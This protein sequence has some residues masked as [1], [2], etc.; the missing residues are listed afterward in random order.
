MSRN[1][2][3]RSSL[4]AH[5]FPSFYACYLLKSIQTPQSRATYIGSTPNPPRRIRQHNGEITQ[6]AW[7]TKNKRPWVMQMIVHGFPSKLAAL[8]FEWAWQHPHISRHLRDDTGK[9]IFMDSR[10]SKYLKMNI[11][12]VRRMISNHPYNTWPL[13]VKLFTEEAVKCWREVV[14]DAG[15][16]PLPPGFTSTIE[17]EGVDGNSGNPGSGRLGPI[18]VNDEAFT[19]AYLAKTTALLATSRPLEC[20]ICREPLRSFATVFQQDPLATALCPKSGCMAVSHL[21]CLSQKFLREQSADTGMVPRGGVCNSCRS[22][23]LWGDIVRGSYRRMAPKAV[24]QPQDETQSDKGHED[25]F[26]GNSPTIHPPTKQKR[27]RGERKATS[28][29]RHGSHRNFH[30]TKRAAMV[31]FLTLTSGLP[32]KVMIVSPTETGYTN[33]HLNRGARP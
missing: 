8:Q 1:P 24:D 33:Q 27:S 26:S 30:P 15:S 6:G 31:N 22:Y 29:Q 11:Q 9:S 19:S 14:D 7:K 28:K 32:M 10:K 20:S 18:N 21:A 2:T 4:F 25:P 5:T 16:D 3:S 17:L 23:T 12:I 13:H